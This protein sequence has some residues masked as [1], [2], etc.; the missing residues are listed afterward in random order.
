MAV[1][2]I[3]GRAG[4]GKTR[5]C[6][7]AVRR[8]LGRS[9]RGA[10]LVLL[11]PEQATYQVERE[12][13]ATPGLGGYCRAYVLSFRRLAH[14][15]FLD[16]GGPGLPTIEAAGRQM[17]LRSILKRRGDD[18]RL[19]KKAARQRGFVERLETTLREFRTH[20]HGADAL[21][22]ELALVESRGGDSMLA[23]KLHDLALIV[24]EYERFLAE[25]YF[26]PDGFLD[27][28]PPRL[29]GKNRFQ[30]A[31][32][33]IDG[34]ASFTG[35]E[36]KVLEALIRNAVEVRVA[37][38]LDEAELKSDDDFS[39][40]SL[41]RETHDRLREMAEVNQVPVR[42]PVRLPGKGQKTRFSKTPPLAVLERRIFEFG[43]P[44]GS[45]ATTDGAV[46]LF[47]AGDQRAE[48]REVALEILRL[49]R[50]GKYRFR[51][52]AV[53][54][55]DLAPYRPLI[56]T[57][58]S[59]FE[60][61]HFIDVRRDVAHHP[62]VELVRAAL[63]VVARGWR[64]PDVLRYAKTDLAPLERAEIDQIENYVLSHGIDGDLWTADDAWGFRRRMSLGEDREDAESAGPAGELDAGRRTL[65]EPLRRFE[66]TV[67]KG[68]KT[69]REFCAALFAFLETLE[70]PARIEDWTAEAEGEGRLELA[71]EHRQV[72]GALVGL[73]DQAV[74][75]LGDD[76]VELDEFAEILESG[77]AGVRLRLIP[78][79]LDQVLVGAI[80]RSRHPEIR[81]AFV[82]G[83]N[84]R[85]FP[86][87]QTPDVVFG[88][89]EREHLAADGVR[90]GPPS[91][92]RMLQERFLAYIAFT[93]PSERLYVSYA[94][95]DPDGK[96]L[97][98]SVFLDDLRECFSDLEEE[99]ISEGSLDRVAHWRAATSGLAAA[100][101][102]GVGTDGGAWLA[103]YE[104][105][106]RHGDFTEALRR[107]VGGLADDNKAP[108][109]DRRVAKQVY[110]GR[111]ES[112][113]SRLECFAACPFQHFARYGLG[114]KERDRFELESLDLGS[115]Y[116][117][118]LSRA[119][120]ALSGGKPLDWGT[121][122]PERA[123]EVVRKT[124][125]ELAPKLRNEI[126][127]SSAHNRYLLAVANRA[128][129][130][131][132][133][134]HIE[135][136]KRDGFLQ[137]AAEL[138]FG[139]GG[140]LGELEIPFGDGERM[141]LRGRIDR[142]DR[143][144]SD[145]RV[146]RVIDFKTRGR[147][148]R[149]SDLAYGL[150][151]QLPAYL[152]AV[153]VATR[154]RPPEKKPILVGALYM[155]ILRETQNVSPGA[156]PADEGAQELS[157][158]RSRGFFDFGRAA[159]F[160]SQLETGGSSPVVSLQIKKDGKPYARSDAYEEDGVQVLLKWTYKTMRSLAKDIFDG[161]IAVA[162]YQ[163]GQAYPCRWCEFRPVCRFDARNQKY[164]KLQGGLD[165][166]WMRGQLSG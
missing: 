148:F 123:V 71:D 31:H 92:K 86:M 147:Q 66:K 120:E 105:M 163:L 55:R 143:S 51:E 126:F 134:S 98:P 67:G 99:S 83:L 50:E 10:P 64:T 1:Q 75:A 144:A 26:D 140:K 102:S 53:I 159:L 113:V 11:V 19:F 25:R 166:E 76:K 57:A 155:P 21:R 138:A 30:K 88:D 78:P 18:L 150:S 65:V 125:E 94:K 61:P 24:E 3:F 116:H 43:K 128:L 82:I 154:D 127:L 63:A 91:D 13:V 101:R 106:R 62:L 131:F 111:G 112:S 158:W 137:A 48:V 7:D 46:R 47:A 6:L 70:C 135:A 152:L 117:E 153:G 22:A 44:A 160:D 34:F 58:F 119:Y 90:L 157:A 136:S 115:L 103:L 33:W 36:E 68:G 87:P 110:G 27:L 23:A 93:R 139:R 107:R 96:S 133:R 59:D 104:A 156:V 38:C 41:L 85:I 146:V 118:A 79:A 77:L 122:D 56:E 145:E 35:Q 124:V 17:I 4:S 12:L 69:V 42:P 74:A 161:R 9:Q 132:V 32:I 164:R 14:R 5:Y 49:C 80:E 100:L 20:G 151:L 108:D 15:V 97:Q 142:I 121:V 109:L 165:L 39:M 141:L 149:T 95:A 73:L 81:A 130:Q 72:W 2:F 89:R 52:I 37:L 45:P 40:F 8:E 162:P 16:T 84:E 129:E 114:L 60:I 29:D 28:L 54:A